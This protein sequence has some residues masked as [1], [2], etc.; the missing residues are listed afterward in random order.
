VVLHHAGYSQA[1][2]RDVF[3]EVIGANKRHR[4]EAQRP[5]LKL[6]VNNPPKFDEGVSDAACSVE[7]LEKSAAWR[8]CLRCA[9]SALM[10]GTC[11]A[12]RASHDPS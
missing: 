6:V 1:I 5:Q 9:A 11:W 7:P 3:K 2:N 4:I 8:C 12:C 10:K